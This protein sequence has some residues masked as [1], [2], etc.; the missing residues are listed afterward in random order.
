MSQ[1]E[2]TSR[3]GAAGHRFGPG[4]QCTECGVS[5]DQH[6]QAPRDCQGAAAKARALEDP[7]EPERSVAQESRA[8]SS[9]DVISSPSR[10]SF[11]T[12]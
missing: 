5:W 9:K 12:R 11:P 10:I 8:E 2:G 6:Q 7:V 4:L 3:P 1:I